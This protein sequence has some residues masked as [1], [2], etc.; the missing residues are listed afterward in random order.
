MVLSRTVIIPDFF[1]CEL[2]MLASVKSIVL[3]S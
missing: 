3:W 2:H 1:T